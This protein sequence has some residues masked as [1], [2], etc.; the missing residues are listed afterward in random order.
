MSS[1]STIAG[2]AR[3][4]PAALTPLKD[5]GAA[6]DEAAFA[7]Y[8]QYLRAGGADGVLALGSTGEGILLSVAERKRVVELYAAESLPVIAH[9]GAQTT[10]TRSSWPGMPRASASPGWR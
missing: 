5:G 9:C 7:P 2:M 4:F 8:V 1:D 6:L 10:A 3:M